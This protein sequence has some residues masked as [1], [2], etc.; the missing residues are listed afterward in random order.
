MEIILT[1]VITALICLV[2]SM[3]VL[4]TIGRSR[5]RL[6]EEKERMHKKEMEDLQSRFELMS[7]TLCEQ[8]KNET[9][10]IL[11]ER[12]SEL[13]KSS[14]ESL[15]K[16][17]NPLKE[18]IKELRKVMEESSRE[19]AERNGEMKERIR[20]LMEETDSTRKTAE[21]LSNALRHRAKVQ[22]D[23][24]EVELDELLSSQGLIKGVH[25]DTQASFTTEA[26]SRLRPDLIIHLDEQKEL[27]IDAK[28]SL[29]AFI[30]YVNAE[31]EQERELALSKHVESIKAH[32]KEL[33]QKDYA[34][35]IKAPK[36]SC[37]Y[38]IMFVPTMGALSA[39]LNKYPRLWREAADMNVYMADEQNLYGALRLVKLTWTNIAQEQ[40]H[41][42]V[43]ELAEEMIN[44]VGLFYKEYKI[45]GEALSNAQEAY[46]KS[47]KKLMEGGPSI[48][49]SA[50]NL[51]ELGVKNSS[52]NPVPLIES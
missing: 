18:N 44:R 22:G 37:G 46:E 29:T 42:K 47:N 35:L 11:K 8:V 38:V 5:Q 16:I 1:F 31:N 27:I 34:S 13:S 36:Q 24:G 6:L 43:Y 20:K 50:N 9:A 4:R 49:K 7:K 15:D 40:N 23:W 48:I 26:N 33:A 2:V 51:L 19:Q 10:S 14:N 3:M 30:D 39:A 52:K 25:Y 32:V 28:V 41:Q 17:V 12:Q 45:I 21:E